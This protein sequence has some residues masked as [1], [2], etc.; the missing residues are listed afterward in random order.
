MLKK[1]LR[2]YSAFLSIFILKNAVSRGKSVS[3]KRAVFQTFLRHS[4]LAVLL[5]ADASLSIAAVVEFNST[6]GTTATNGLHFYIEDTTH[7]Q[8]LRSNN[9]GQ[10]YYPAAVPPSASLDNG[11]FLLA[12]TKV[13]GPSHTVTTFNPTGGMYSTYS[14]T[15]TSPANPSSSGTQQIA[16]NNLGINNGP[17]ISINW[18]YTTP[19]DF[20]TAEVTLTIPAAYPVSVANP[21]RYYHVFDTYLGGSDSGCGVK[22]TDSNSKTVVGTYPPPSGTSCPSS[23]SI[24]SNVSIVESFRERSGL[25][26]SSYCA[27]GW[28]SFYTNGTSNCSVLQTASLSNTIVTTYQDTGIGVEFDFTA[29]GTYTFSYDFVIGSTIVPAYD[30]LE[31]VHDGSATSCP[32]NV[33]ILACTSS[34]VPCPAGASVNTGTLTGT[35]TVT[36]GVPAVSVTPASFSIGPTVY[37]PTVVL[38]GSG[39]GTYTLGIS[40]ISG[41]VPLNG[42]KCSNGSIA[43]SCVMI[44]TSTPCV[45]NFECMETS[46]VT[47][48]N[49]VSSPSLRNPLLTKL[50][51]T[52]FTFDV[53]ALQASGA[54]STGYSGAVTVEL[55]DATAKPA[56]SCSFTGTALASQSLT[57][58][59]ADNGRKTLTIPVN[60]PIAYPNLRCQV[61]QT[62]PTAVSGCSSD[63]FAVRPSAI[64]LAATTLAGQSMATAPSATATPVIRAGT[65]FKLSGATSPVASYAGSLLLDTS[66]LTAQTT[67]PGNIVASGGVVGA[68]T[69]SLVA[70][71]AAIN[72][73]YNEV[74][75]LYLAAGAYRDDSFTAIDSANGDCITSTAS[76]NNLSD[77]LVSGKYGCSIGN[78]IASTFGRFIPD[79]FAISAVSLTAACTSGASF[80]YFGQDGFT[81]GFTMTAQ[82]L[83][84]STT[85]NYMGAFGKLQLN[86]FSNYL[87]YGFSASPLSV[88]S[89]L[90]GSGTVAPSANPAGSIWSSGIVSATANHQISRPTALVAP[91]SITISAAPT[92]GEVPAAS[93]ATA[94]GGATMRYGRMRIQNAHGSELLDLPVPLIA[95]YWNGAMWTQNIDDSCTSIVAPTSGAGLTFVAEVAAG[96]RGNHLSAA[97][98]TASVSATGKLVAGDAKFKLSK[99]GTGNNGY[100]DI[101]FPV[102]L[103]LKFPWKG[104]VDLDPPGRA[105]F[106]IYKNPNEFIYMRELH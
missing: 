69:S 44:F 95:Q 101:A 88:G 60:L 64:T 83:A 50:A 41:T 59:A 6:G 31:I 43:T 27:A 94:L 29:P 92:D 99:P 82:S 12:N 105:T 53:L 55:F 86:G 48:N 80:S 2:L 49:L 97:E 46:Q 85:Q 90:A 56:P 57:Y 91:S 20:L 24:P 61:K 71:A 77:T 66:K 11:V 76:D 58:L 40:G 52:G 100:I 96:A 7:M 104:G 87:N 19:L 9:T 81:T 45:A 10:V 26:F 103:W 74:G 93:I 65:G 8:V 33:I 5:C 75:Y 89:T 32:E 28:A 47:Y 62:A 63:A 21:V 73:T 13:Y 68:L 35:L 102:P 106:G 34:T 51:G 15:A 84:N 54:I 36:P 16:T 78:K 22:F 14:I 38:Q 70:N 98:T 37:N 18:K 42:V 23:T 39:A 79:H 67:V 4:M 72:A 17:Q 25:L 3:Q 30:H 1:C